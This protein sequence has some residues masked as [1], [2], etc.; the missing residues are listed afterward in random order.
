M[1]ILMCGGPGNMRC[2]I[3]ACADRLEI[4]ISESVHDRSMYPVINILFGIDELRAIAPLLGAMV[5][6]GTPPVVYIWN[7][8]D[9]NIEVLVVFRVPNPEPELLAEICGGTYDPIAGVLNG[10]PCTEVLAMG[11]TSVPSYAVEAFVEKYSDTKQA[12]VLVSEASTLD[13]DG[14]ECLQIFPISSFERKPPEFVL[15]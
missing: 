13:E 9:V 12:F 10:V 2:I 15:T 5:R 14:A 11:E 1:E 4:G 8:E 7:K 6:T 3:D